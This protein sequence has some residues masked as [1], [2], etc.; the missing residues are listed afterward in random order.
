MRIGVPKEIKAHEYRVSV[1]PHGVA[2][3]VFQ[4]HQVFV[5]QG[6]GEAIGFDDR[7]YALAGAKLVER[8][9][10][11]WLQAELVV[12]VKEPLPIE[13]GYFRQG[14][15]LLTY[16]HLAAEPALTRALLDAKVTAIAYETIEDDHGALPL[17]APMSQI[18]GRVA[19][20]IGAY[21]LQKAQGGCGVLLGPVANLSPARV[22]VLGAGNVGGQAAIVARGLGA[23]VIVL[24]HSEEALERTRQ[25]LSLIH[26]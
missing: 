1:T 23:K 5:E 21:Y 26:I 7:D 13:Y 16:L 24:D 3:L 14:L 25:L 6:A 17:L 18:A 12:K 2:T 11:V 22:V 20:Q 8:A 15:I 19:V 9:S 4:K 10:D